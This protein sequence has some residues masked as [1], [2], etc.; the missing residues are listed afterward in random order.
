MG[1]TKE[2]LIRS[3]RYLE[4]PDADWE[5][6]LASRKYVIGCY[7]AN[8]S[9]AVKIKKP[10]LVLL[11]SHA[12]GRPYLTGSV[13][14]HKKLGYWLAVCYDNFIDPALPTVDFNAFMPAKDVM[15]NIDTFMITH[16]QTWGGVSYPFIW[17]LRLASGLAAQFEYVYCVNGD[18]IIEK[19]DGFPEL[20]AALGDADIMSSGPALEREIGTAGLL[21]RSSAFIKIGKH[22]IDHVVPFEEY[23]KSTQ[24]FGNTE[25]R[26]AVAARELGLKQVIVEPPYNEQFHIPG[27]GFWYKTI[28]FRH[29][30]GEHN[31]AY[32]Y[33]GIPPE[34]QYFDPRHMGDEYNRIKE[35]WDLIKAAGQDEK[36]GGTG[37]ATDAKA[38]LENWWAK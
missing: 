1:I 36:A 2:D 9:W 12:A 23:E 8:D 31:Y 38:I 27:H 21:M 33:K 7:E 3:G 24:G 20:L 14:T 6:E 22:L 15:D 35:Y 28:G 16:H 4:M 30:H 29:I 11:I 19:P 17:S 5:V 37:C 18:C 26:L 13:N 10:V 25:G 34:P 32:R